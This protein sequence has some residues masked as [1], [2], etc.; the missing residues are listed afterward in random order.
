VG[1]VGRRRVDRRWVGRLKRALEAW[2]LWTRLW[3]SHAEMGFLVLSRV[4]IFLA[5]VME[6]VCY[7]ETVGVKG[8]AR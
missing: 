2:V 8:G 3:K 6:S 7:H 5:A 1:R 4:Q